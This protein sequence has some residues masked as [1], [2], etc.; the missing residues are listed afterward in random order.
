MK[1]L[2]S[3]TVAVRRW[4]LAKPAHERAKPPRGSQKGRRCRLIRRQFFR[5]RS[6]FLHGRGGDCELVRD[7]RRRE[8]DL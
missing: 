5:D 2:H 6:C 8:S 1:Y 7:D 3:V 4:G